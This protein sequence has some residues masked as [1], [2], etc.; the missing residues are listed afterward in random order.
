MLELPDHFSSPSQKKKEEEKL[1]WRRQTKIEGAPT[2]FIIYLSSLQGCFEGLKVSPENDQREKAL[3]RF[4][5]L[6]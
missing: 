4:H 5:T 3:T 6:R 2:H 1:G